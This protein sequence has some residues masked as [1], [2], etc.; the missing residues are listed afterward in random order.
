MKHFLKTILTL[1]VLAALLINLPSFALANEDLTSVSDIDLNR[2]MGRWFEIARY[3]HRYQKDCDYS[4]AHYK[5]RKDERIDVLN[6][7]FKNERIHSSIRGV[8]KP[9][10]SKSNTKL[11]IDF[12]FF[13]KGKYW[14][15]NID[16]DYNWVV[17]S[18]PKRKSLFIMS[19]TKH[20]DQ[21]TLDSILIDLEDKG[22]DINKLVYDKYEHQKSEDKVK[23]A[24]SKKIEEMYNRF[25]GKNLDILDGFYSNDVHFI[26]PVADVQGLDE[27]KDYYN[28]MYQNVE[29][30][31]FEFKNFI[32][33]KDSIAAEWVMTLTSKKLNS[34]KPFDVVGSSI[35]ILNEKGEIKYHR[36]YLDLGEMIYEKIPVVGFVIRSVKKN[37]E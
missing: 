19:R 2:Y 16:K 22:F 29:N 17:V 25:D 8:A 6:I 9:S 14:I 35:F 28:K 34:S 15:I 31:H 30:I 23:S 18:E 36:D 5:L 13:R 12:G 11:N 20:L 26:D 32:E 4:E 33:G 10:N 37:L 3:P 24:M 21:Q 1:K 27:L 7:C